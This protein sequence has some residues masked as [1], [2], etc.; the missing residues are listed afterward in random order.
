MTEFYISSTKYSIQ[1]RQT[2]KH[3][4]VYDVVFR[5][6]TPDG[7]EKQKRL[8]GYTTKALAKQAYAEFVTERCELVKNNPL[9]KR[10][11][12]KEIPTVGELIR[13]YIASLGNQNK[14]SSIYD[15]RN[16][17]D[18][19]VIPKYGNT[20][21]TA[22]TKD[23]L[24][25]W[26]DDLWATR[27]PRTG[28]Y[29]SYAYLSKVRT[30]FG[31]LLAWAESRYGYE[32]H[33]PEVQ[34]PKRR[35]PKKEMRFWTREQFEKFISAVDDPMYHCLFSMLF[36]TGRRFGEVTALTPADVRQESIRW[37][38][39]ITRKTI[40][41]TPYK[42][43]TTKADKSQDVEICPAMRCELAKY[44]PQEPFFFGG[45][46][47]L[48]DKTVTAAFGRYCTTAGME[49]IRLHDLRHSFV[50]MLIHLGANYMVVADMIGDKPEQ[51]MKTYGHLYDSDKHAIMSQIV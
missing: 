26:Q 38:K 29:Y 12:G 7:I 3:G 13:Q 34:K 18:L 25:R 27:N 31:T 28:E 21:I 37:A 35:A 44:T 36:L 23:E 43:T 6:V 46:K 47:P 32:N 1:E 49:P 40:D 39:S 14:E 22:L 48:L 15:K 20:K 5:V 16:I 19:F 30:F 41:D 9:K 4:K 42:V 51:V 11:P 45:D 2:K 24:Y 50:S 8:S 10:D 17:Y 33:L